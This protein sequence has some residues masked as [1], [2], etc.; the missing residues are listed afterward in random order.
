MKKLIILLLFLLIPSLAFAD[1]MVIGSGA[2]GNECTGY[3]VCQN[4]EGTGYDNSETWTEGIVGGGTVNEDYTTT[5]LR[6]AQSLYVGSTTYD[7]NYALITFTPSQPTVGIRMLFR[8]LEITDQD[9]EFISFNDANCKILTNGK[10]SC[11]HGSTEV[12]GAYTLSVNTTYYIWI[13]YTVGT[14]N[15]GILSLYVATTSTKPGSPDIATTA[16]TGTSNV[17][18]CYV[19]SHYELKS[20]FDQILIKSSTIG[21]GDVP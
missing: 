18:E 19:I 2:A 10:L 21:S 7:L 6:G 3:I 15:N 14:G 9:S 16:G 17:N 11:S 20:I 12:Y 5:A 13:D 4:F 8:P 1:G